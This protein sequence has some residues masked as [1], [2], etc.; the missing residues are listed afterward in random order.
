[1]LNWGSNEACTLHAGT[2]WNVAMGALNASPNCDRTT[3]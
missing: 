1:M 2:V 3:F